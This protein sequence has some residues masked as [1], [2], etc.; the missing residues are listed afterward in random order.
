MHPG[1]DWFTVLS[2]TVELLLGDRVII[3]E[4]GQA[5]SFSTMVPHAFGA[6]GGPAEA[7]AILDHDG[8]CLHLD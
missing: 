6:V 7:L 4:N 5:A 1:H 2:G 8:R 3:V